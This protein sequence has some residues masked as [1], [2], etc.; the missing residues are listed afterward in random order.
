MDINENKIEHDAAL[1]SMLDM[2][3]KHLGEEITEEQLVEF[4]ELVSHI[5]EYS[6]YMGF[7]HGQS[8]S[9]EKV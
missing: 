9:Q 7:Q 3:R 4:N 2:N 1:N 5:F 8:N 6:Y